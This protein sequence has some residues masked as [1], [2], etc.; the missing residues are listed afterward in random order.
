MKPE[1]KALLAVVLAMIV[2]ATAGAAYFVF[3]EPPVPVTLP[4]PGGATFTSN[5]TVHWAAHFT[6]GASGGRL[7]GAWTAYHGQGDLEL[8]VANGTVP[9]PAP[10]G[11]YECPALFLWNERNGTVHMLLGPGAYTIYWNTGSCASAA[12]IMVTQTI[13]VVAS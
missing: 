6:V 13:Q 10:G 7:V 8:I 1:D 11:I 3:A 5:A 2:V 9:K 12:Q 4:V